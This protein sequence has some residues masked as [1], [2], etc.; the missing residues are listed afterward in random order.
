MNALEL[1]TNTMYHFTHNPLESKDAE[2]ALVLILTRVS[3]TSL[4]S[5]GL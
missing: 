1:D 2:E 4:L 3:S 5:K